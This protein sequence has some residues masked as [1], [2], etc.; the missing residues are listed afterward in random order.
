[1]FTSGNGD[2][3]GYDDDHAG[4]SDGY[5]DGHAG[6]DGDNGDNDGYGACN[7]VDCNLIVYC[8]IVY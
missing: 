7:M 3:K 1:M 6:D 2:D 4:D 5:G 8:I